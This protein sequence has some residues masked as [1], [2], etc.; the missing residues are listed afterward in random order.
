MAKLMQQINRASGMMRSQKLIEA[1]LNLDRTIVIA[2]QTTP[3][4]GPLYAPIVAS[5]GSARSRVAALLSQ[6]L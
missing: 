5:A 1:I 6:A 3:S 2:D 4:I